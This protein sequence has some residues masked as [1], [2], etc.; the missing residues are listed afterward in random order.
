MRGTWV[1]VASVAI[2]GTVGTLLGTAIPV[3]W[4]TAAMTGIGLFTLVLGIK[5]ALAS[6]N[7]LELVAAISIG[8]VIGT[9]LHF[10]GGI[11]AFAEWAQTQATSRIT[12]GATGRFSEAIV[13]CTILFCV[14]PMT[15]LGCLQDALEDK[16]D[17]LYVKSA[18]D[19]ISAI[20]FGAAL[21][22][23]VVATAAI[24]LVIQGSLS[25]LA[26]R[27]RG[28]KNL[29]AYIEEASAVGGLLIVSIS[30]GLL[31]I[32]QFPTADY[33]PAILLAPIFA[34][35]Q[36]RMRKTRDAT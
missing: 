31:Q 19:G 9:A 2:G 26:R 20:F 32:R 24:L 21:G 7:V 16:S 33:L 29:P 12:G 3:A 34:A 36:N 11:E 35:I 28:V 14:G 8:G 27:L 13:T 5:M 17:I 22:I 10:S 15:L 25:L 18:M 1:N 4:Q 30:F 23:G 6:K